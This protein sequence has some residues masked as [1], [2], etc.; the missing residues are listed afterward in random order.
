M[1]SW[2]GKGFDVHQDADRR[3]HREHRGVRERGQS[4]L[5]GTSA[6]GELGQIMVAMPKTWSPDLVHKLVSVAASVIGVGGG[7]PGGKL[8]GGSTGA[9]G[10]LPANWKTIACSS[11]TH[12]FTKFA[13]AGVAGNIFAESGGH[14]EILQIGGGGGGG[15]I[16]W[17]PYP[18][19]YITGNARPT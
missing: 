7:G 16:Q 12:G 8:P 15:L 17:T 6:A 13:A 3:G 18:A 5:I 1:T 10:C 11:S 19:G 9:V 14:P 2:L 4:K